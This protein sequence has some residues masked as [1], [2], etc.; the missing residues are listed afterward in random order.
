MKKFPI[1]SVAM[2]GTS[3][4]A[5]GALAMPLQS[6]SEEGKPILTTGMA[7]RFDGGFASND[8]KL[9]QPMRQG[10]ADTTTRNGGSIIAATEFL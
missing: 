10:K 6:M 1:S 2:A 5:T 7:A 4:L 8:D 3:T 9:T